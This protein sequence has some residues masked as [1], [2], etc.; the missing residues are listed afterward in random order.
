MEMF[1]LVTQGEFVLWLVMSV[2]AFVVFVCAIRFALKIRSLLI[3]ENRKRPNSP[4]RFL[5]GASVRVS[6]NT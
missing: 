6:K 1:G 5:F 3:K 4:H 2:V